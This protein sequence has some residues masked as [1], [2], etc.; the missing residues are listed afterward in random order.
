MRL[1]AFIFAILLPAQAFAGSLVIKES[2]PEV[3]GITKATTFGSLQDDFLDTDLSIEEAP[4]YVGEGFCEP[5]VIVGKDT[6]KE[7]SVYFQWPDANNPQFICEEGTEV[8]LAPEQKVAVIK[9]ADSAFGWKTEK[10]IKIGSTLSDIQ[11]KYGDVKFS[12][13]GWDYGGRCC[14]EEGSV[15]DNLGFELDF[16]D[17]EQSYFD[18]KTQEFV[19]K[20][21]LGDGVTANTKNLPQVINDNIVI[22]R[23]TL[24]FYE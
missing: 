7:F 20:N 16:R 21:L 13:L 10:G 5:G 15:P 23:I 4:V 19:D 24:G 2:T 18:K 3:L 14:L 1:P 11:K 6:D 22:K 17:Y 12:G 8:K 9:F